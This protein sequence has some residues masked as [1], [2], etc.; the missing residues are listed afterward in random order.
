MVTWY[1]TIPLVVATFSESK[2]AAIG[3]HRTSLS[4]AS[5]SAGKPG[6]SAPNSR[7]V[8]VR[9]RQLGK[10]RRAGRAEGKGGVPLLGSDS[11]SDIDGGV[12][13]G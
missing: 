1:K 5:R 9:A 6:P 4:R 3:M 13:T 12:E 7:A 2:P 11:A 10:R 8:A